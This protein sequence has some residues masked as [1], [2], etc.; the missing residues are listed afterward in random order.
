VR[1][2]NPKSEILSPKRPTNKILVAP[3]NWGLGHAARCIPIINAL[4]HNNYTPIIGSDGDAQHLLRKEFPELKFYE[5][6][7]YEITYTKKGNNLKYRM[8]WAAPSILRASRKEKILV[9][10]IIQ[11]EGISG[12]IS[13]NR[14]GVRSNKVPSIYMTHQLKVFSGNT[15]FLTSLV[16]QKII[17]KFDSCWVPDYQ[18]DRSLAGELS[19]LTNSKME[20]KYLGA[21]SRFSYKKIPKKNAL[22]IVLSG[23]EPQRSLLEEKLL[24]QLQRYDKNVLFVRGI[25]SEK[26]EVNQLKNIR[27]VNYM[28]KEELEKAINESELVLARS[29]Y[30]TIMDLE[31]LK[32]NAFFIPT[33][34][35]FE[36]EYLA[37][38]LEKK[39]IAPYANQN[40]FKIKMLYNIEHYTGFRK[41]EGT[42]SLDFKTLFDLYFS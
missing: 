16:H 38:Y 12:I 25:V 21:I 31:K 34:G 23:P 18:G 37:K 15:S 3:L 27:I 6:P 26:Q 5:L 33:P 24:T 32:A 1:K 35:Q 4:I 10:E 30:T 14:F 42:G 11:K 8:L 13:D 22:L 39:R 28:L 7:S 19:N 9:N 20:F 41:K 17:A 40:N 2:S 29:G 36:Q